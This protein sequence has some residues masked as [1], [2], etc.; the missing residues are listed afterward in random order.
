MMKHNKKNNRKRPPPPPPPAKAL[1]SGDEEENEDF[2]DEE[3]DEDEAFNSEDERKYGSFFNNKP[4]GKRQNGSD[5]D[6][7]DESGSGGED[8][9]DSGD[10][11]GDD[12]EDGSEDG[13]EN[14]SADD[15]DEEEDSQ[16]GD[17][18]QYMLA[19]LD[20]L[21][22][23]KSSSRVNGSEHENNSHDRKL[24]ANVKESQFS[25]SV[26]KS[27]ELTLEDMMEGI[28]DTKG[29]SA[30][31]K[32]MKHV[33]TGKAAS[34]ALPRVVQDR[35][36]RKVHYDAQAKK[37]SGWTHVVQENRQAD[38]LDFRPQEQLRVTKDVLVE[39]F[40]PT[41]D[42]EKE[43]DAA[44][45]EAGQKDEEAILNAEEQALADELGTNAITLEEFKKR[46]GQLAKMRALMFYHEQRRH[47]MNKIK[48]KKYRRIRKRQ[49]DRLKGAEAEENPDVAAD[50][51][52]KEEVE[53]I[54]ERMTL[55][56]KNTSKW[57]RRV[58]KRGK[59]VDLETRRALSAQ[60]KRGEDLRQ[61]MM[62]DDEDEDDSDEDLA[63][64][65]RKVLEDKEDGPNDD[66]I[67]GKGLFKLAFMQ[68]GIEKERQRAKEEARA[69]LKEL[70]ADELDDEASFSSDDDKGA[71]LSSSHPKKKLRPAS[72]EEMKSVLKEGE[73]VAAGLTF[74]NSTSLTVSGAI[75]V[76][77]EQNDE[78]NAATTTVSEHRASMAGVK[79][80]D[81]DR[82]D[83]SSSSS[84]PRKHRANVDTAA[85]AD[86]N[87]GEENPWM[88]D[89]DGQNRGSDQKKKRQRVMVDVSRAASLLDAS[90]T[91]PEADSQ[92][93]TATNQ[94][95]STTASSTTT[96][97]VN[98]EDTSGASTLNLTSLPQEELVRR[99]FALDKDHAEQEFSKEKEKV[100]DEEDGDPTR[101]IKGSSADDDGLVM[102]W[103][104]WTGM[105]APAALPS[106]RKRH[107]LPAKLQ[108]P[109]KTAEPRPRQDNDRP[110]LIIR[111]R[112]LKQLG[113][114]MLQEIPYP[115]T[116]REEYE[117]A[118]TGGIG[119]EWTVSGSFQD[120]TR[121]AIQTRAGRIIQPIAA[122]AKKRGLPRP[123]AK[124]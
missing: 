87:D 61:K 70:E 55:A 21:S 51:K 41:T 104:S 11:S 32:S 13:S 98:A 101:K 35:L 57:A 25:S 19:L 56:H 102:G 92:R 84:L 82:T 30:L 69:L 117:R 107:K 75:Q 48:S 52:E 85:A 63:E 54:K 43:L 27:T 90:N 18:G 34:A 83:R 111:E 53:R 17:G 123:A 22:S 71:K 20:R 118:M 91:A 65:A 81:T 96:N 42:F 67:Q 116:T 50:L 86:K 88:I 36:E 6:K 1:K 16:D 39:S 3:I 49:R 7:D 79:A 33:A 26:L 5:H 108:P 112:R 93:G 110:H 46:R 64:A 60:L 100:R 115:Y 113:K 109:R 74:G 9:N 24:A 73:L 62:G 68:R 124:F 38:T 66:A 12:S 78:G 72:K 47:H 76:G 44:L 4:A 31:A 99:A 103:G 95:K 89:E 14:G 122:T 105:G 94:L 80:D 10:D 29:F 15:D 77:S 114:H 59:N 45:I 40:Q 58:L 37:I 2:E 28:K 97:E 23:A 106:K 119:T 8:A 121:P 120:L